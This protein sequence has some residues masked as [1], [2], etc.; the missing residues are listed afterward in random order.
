MC[1]FLTTF[2]AFLSTIMAKTESNINEVFQFLR[3]LAAHNERPWFKARKEQYDALRQAW[4][5]DMERLINLVA[6][7]D[8]KARGLTVRQAVYRIYRDI[9]FSPDKRPYKTYFSGVIGAG[10]R[11]CVS[12]GYYV[13]L[14]PGNSMLC[15][16]V[17]WPEKDKLAAIRSLIDAEAD[18]WLRLMANPELTARY[19][20]DESEALK[21]VP[22]GYPKDHPMA[23]YLRFKSFIFVKKLDESYFDCDDWVAR[24]NDDLRPLKPVHD[25]LDYVFE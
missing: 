14:E 19:S 8:D 16:G 11:K 2:V 13:H 10:G 17:W 15:G 18:E 22:K 25:F 6:Q 1:D 23:R 20:L 9:R 24:V 4:E 12:S 21:T 7:W 3:L 5:H